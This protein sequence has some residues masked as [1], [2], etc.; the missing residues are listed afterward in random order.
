M[1]CYFCQKGT[2]EIDFK[3]TELLRRFISGL[4]KIRPRKKTGLC[5]QHQRKLARAIKRAR[6]LGLL[7]PTG[8]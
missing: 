3:N 8:K 5:G 7:A 4:G 2:E 6:F 1:N